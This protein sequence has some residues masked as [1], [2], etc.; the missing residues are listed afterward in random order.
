MDTQTERNGCLLAPGSDKPTASKFQSRSVIAHSCYI[1]SPHIVEGLILVLRK[2][3][4]NSHAKGKT[5][6]AVL[7][8][9]RTVYVSKEQWDITWGCG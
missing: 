8:Y 7:C 2:A 9:D 1:A 4:L 3:L 5:Q 6:R